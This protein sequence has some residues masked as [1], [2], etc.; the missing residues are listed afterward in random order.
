MDSHHMQYSFQ[1][2]K[3]WVSVIFIFSDELRFVIPYTMPSSNGI[4]PYRYAE[5]PTTETKFL[6]IT[7][8]MFS[9]R[10]N[11]FPSTSYSKNQAFVGFPKSHNI[12]FYYPYDARVVV[13][14]SFSKRS[15]T[16]SFILISHKFNFCTYFWVMMI[17]I[18]DTKPHNF[19]DMYI[20][21]IYIKKKM[22]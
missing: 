19:S 16:F 17:Y 12:H 1:E 22:G 11:N 13:L 10:H 6:L 3:N 21:I 8:T 20:N 2:E 4:L 15:F 5:V 18:L 9:V 7:R 14:G